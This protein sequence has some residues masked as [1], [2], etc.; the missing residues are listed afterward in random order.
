MIH[1]SRPQTLLRR[2]ALAAL[3][4][5][6]T[7]AGC[8]PAAAAPT[9][10]GA[11]P[12]AA[13]TSAPATAAATITYAA[14][15]LPPTPDAPSA[16][17]ADTEIALQ[18]DAIIVSGP[19][20]TADGGTVTITR[21]GVYRLSGAL[22][23]G[24]VIV[25]T[26][27]DETVTLALA[28]V[29]I[30]CASSAPLYIARANKV[31]VLL[32]AGSVNRLED[33]A[34]Y[35]VDGDG[36]PDAA[37]FSKGDL[38]ITGEG[39]LTVRAHYRDGI[40]SKDGLKITGGVIAVEAADDGLRGRDYVA[41][42]GGDITVTAA[43]D[44]LKATHD[45][46]PARGLVQIDGGRLTITAGADGIQAETTLA[47]TGGEL[48]LTT[49]GG[50]AS[51]SVQTPA[52]GGRGGPQ[53]PVATVAEASASM[54]GLKA[55]IAL[56]ITDG[57]V[58]IDAADDA[59]HSNGDVAISGGVL[60]LAS[61]DDGV[62][63]DASLTISGGELRVLRSY[64]G[65]EAAQITISGGNIAVVARDDGL[66]VAGG[67]DGSS[68]NGRPGQNAFAA[69][70]NQWLEISGGTVV[71]DAS[72]DGIDVN[73]SVVM[74]GG[75]VL[76]S[77]P[78]ASMNGALDYDRGFQITGG[79]LVAAGSA[80]M[81]QAPDATSTQYAVLLGLSAVQPAGSIV[82]VA[83][84]AG[85]AVLTFAPAKD[86]QTVALSTP[87][88]ALGETYTV[89]TGGS[90]TGEVGPAG[91][92]SGGAYTSGV[93]ALTFTINDMVT[94]VGI[95]LRGGLRGAPGQ[96]LQPGQPARPGR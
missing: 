71:V 36:E 25:D 70:A 49:G 43:G 60:T 52:G 58:T 4:A 81:A 18:G 15:D 80:G 92:Y 59:V 9:A 83:D 65:I 32:V 6:T 35:Q 48:N 45:E 47:I 64:E 5:A 93:Q 27:D 50:S 1:R 14:E 88:L 86:Y 31:V 53:P 7:L 62:H 42:A 17:A 38:T 76:V 91:L 79:V 54:K 67:V 44:G 61:G 41:I 8:A 51:A 19:G 23:D 57:T 77:G 10:T 84:S 11:T 55:K 24:Q 96:P 78:T 2:V 63:A 68:L 69:T 85:R 28:G 37:L 72:G 20:A 13:A 89:Y 16:V 34:S 94:A 82:H 74:S 33:R 56:T 87:D 66:N 21:A 12:T 39:A 30:T 90:A 40:A 73:G 75:V 29:D 3:L 95:Q 22:E 26:R 46:D